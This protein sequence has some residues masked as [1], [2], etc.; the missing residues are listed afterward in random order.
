MAKGN[1]T[2]KNTNAAA[3]EQ[4][5][6]VR[7]KKTR[8]PNNTIPLARIMP[9]ARRFGKRPWSESGK[10]ALHLA[11]NLAVKWVIDETIA[12]RN[13]RKGIKVNES[14]LSNGTRVA[15]ARM[16]GISD[17]QTFLGSLTNQ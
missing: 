5:K 17:P 7:V 16:Q 4:T 3:A 1:K 10:L 12:R 2:T 11:T 9:F 6:G 14:D 13:E 8:Q 15:F